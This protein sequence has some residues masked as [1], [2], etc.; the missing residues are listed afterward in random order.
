M[1]TDDIADLLERA[2]G[3]DTGAVGE[4]LGRHRK[5]LLRLVD[6]RMDNRLRGR[7]DAS[8]V[9]Q[10]A[11]IEAARRLSECPR[12]SEVPFFVWLR[13]LTTQK[14]AELHRHHLHVKARDANRDVSIFGGQLRE[15][16]SAL[17]AAQLLGRATAPS[18]AAMRTEYH[19]RLRQALDSMESSDREIIVLRH[20]EQ[21]SNVETARVLGLNESTAST[22]HLRALKRLKRILS[23]MPEFQDLTFVSG[24]NREAT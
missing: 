8:D 16:S 4:L 20:F 19:C 24:T 2:R 15:A 21:L 5:R 6:L 13:F 22:R 17:L 23:A 18:K 1:S 11:Y 9:V 12:N 14:L 7:I 10:E 3:G